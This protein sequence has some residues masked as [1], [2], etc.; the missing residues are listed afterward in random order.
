MDW[1]SRGFVWSGRRD[2]N[3]GENRTFPKEFGHGCDDGSDQTP[4]GHHEFPCNPL[5][6]RG[7]EAEGFAHVARRGLI[8]PEGGRRGRSRRTRATRRAREA[9]QPNRAP[10]LSVARPRG[11]G[12]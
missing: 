5:G 1:N 2:S 9:E 8:R 3:P 4:L 6:A 12:P 11:T 10:R 7:P